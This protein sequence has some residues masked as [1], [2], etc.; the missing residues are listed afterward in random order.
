VIQ[1]PKVHLPAVMEAPV[2]K[3]HMQRELLLSLLA[4]SPSQL[5]GDFEYLPD[6]VQSA[7]Q[8]L[9]VFGA[10][11]YVSST[12]IKIVPPINPI[13]KTELSVC[14]G[15]SGFLIRNIISTGFLFA[16]K[17][18]IHAKGTLLTRELHINEVLLT[19][20][21]LI[22]RSN[23]GEWPLILE[24]FNPCQKHIH[25][26]ASTTSQIASGVLIRLA[27]AQGDRR[28]CLLNLVSL[29]YFEM[30][31]AQLNNRGL[32]LSWDERCI[33]MHDHRPIQGG[34]I[35]IQGDWSGAANL[36]C[37]GAM[38]GSISVR[39]LQVNTKQADERILDVLKSYG[40][41][42]QIEGDT[43]SARRG[44]NAAISV[45][46][47]HSPDLFPLLCVLAASAVGKSVIIGTERLKSKE[48]DRLQSSIAML[49]ALGT[50]YKLSGNKISINGG[51]RHKQVHI[52][53]FNDHRMVL[54][55]SVI[56]AME[57]M[58]VSV[59]EFAS[60][61]KSFPQLIPL[62]QL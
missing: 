4:D 7:I 8:C 30:T 27:C 56:A 59:S 51:I 41:D 13:I 33:P 22:K 19:Q 24:Q 15:E 29:P 37:V 36:L 6:D 42:I 12:R 54:A 49:D 25:L 48:S 3:S 2:S 39:G 31:L 46:I 20:L 17:L 62:L 23:Q 47:T 57:G 52:E 21:G 1:L 18:I 26:D 53:T 28:L 5:I 61:N 44:S 10:E 60:L 45:D 55:A 32:H 14:V 35:R 50:E 11:V 40:A 43:I 16:R 38:T 9:E 58:Q 34:A